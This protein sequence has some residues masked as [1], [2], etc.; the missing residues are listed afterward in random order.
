MKRVIFTT[1]DD[2]DTKIEV[3]KNL[4]ADIKETMSEDR[5]KQMLVEEYFDRLVQNKKDYADT[6]GVDFICYRNT[7]KDFEVEAGFEFAKVNLYKHSLFA[8]LAETYDEVMYVDM[9]VVFNTDENVFEEHDLSKGIHI[10]DQDYAIIDKEKSALLFD[11]IGLRSP[12]L[13]YHITKDLLDGADN[14]VLNTGVMLGR[15]EDIRKIQYIDRLQEAI[16]KVN[17]LKDYQPSDGVYNIL[18]LS[19]YPNNESIFSY[20]VEKY[21]VP[22]VLMEEE[23]HNIYSDQPKIGCEGKI[24]H[25]V[26]KQFNRFFRDKT[27]CIYS[28]HI[29]IPTELLDAPKSYKDTKENKSS[30]TKRQLNKWRDDLIKNHQDYAQAIGA[31]YLHYKNDEE[32]EKFADRF[33]DLSVYDQVNL[34]KIWLLDQLTKEY[35]LVM[36]VDLDTHFRSHHN[37][38][39]HVPANY[40][41]CCAYDTADELEITNDSLYFHK[42]N[43]DFRN[44]QAKYWNAHALLTEEGLIGENYA[45]NTGVIVASRYGMDQLDYFSDI[46]EVIETMKELKEDEMSMYP[47]QVRASFGY[48]NE[49]IFGYKSFKNQCIIY[50]LSNMWHTKHHYKAI[51]CFDVQNPRFRQEK[52]AWNARCHEFNTVI[53]HFISK[54]FEL[55]FVD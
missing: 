21:Q 45:F 29:D 6:I 51:E 49:T 19:Y 36:Y 48:D 27:T 25:L 26:N 4:V 10:K 13:K 1:Y 16:D 50:R 9:D 47:S 24:I 2:I 20:I 28:L 15:A 12:T 11:F 18:N 5:A 34:Y 53:T 38:F 14:H 23:W 43:K 54:N 37:I 40:A 31:E 7:M 41:I 42:Y 30:I 39:E 46:D 8:Q 35:D 3:G 32:F 44:P 33:P 55:A 17:I 22:Y 52:T